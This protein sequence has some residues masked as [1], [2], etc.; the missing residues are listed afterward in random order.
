M[1]IDIET[2]RKTNGIGTKTIERIIEQ[3]N[4][5]NDL[6]S[7][8]SMYQPSDTYKINRD[9][10]LWKGDCLELMEHI[11]D[12]S[13]DMILCDLPYGT[14]ACKWDTVIPF[15]PLWD[16]YKRIIKDNGAIVLFGS[17][18]FT[19]KL[20]NSNINNFK[21]EWVWEKQ[22]GANFMGAKYSPIKYH[23]NIVVFGKTNNSKVK[24]YPQK[25]NVIELDDILN[26]NKKE[27]KHF[28]DNRLYDRYGKIDRRKTINNIP[29]PK[30]GHYG[31]MSLKIRNADDGTRFPKSVIKI[32][33]SI[34]KNLHPTQKPV[35]LL[36][37]LVKTYTD[38]NMLVLD[39]TMGVGST[40]VACKNT[41]RKFIGIELDE[42]YFNIASKRILDK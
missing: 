20:I 12:N 40:G 32:N 8:K 36:E 28:M 35:E 16:N 18:P 5:D 34:N 2:L 24:Y 21:Y 31:K 41:N 27:L 22:K 25:T 17:Q 14:T 19:T 13:V 3:Y 30:D 15:E 11:P 1:K 29:N 37:Y 39:N 7:Y 33:K 9:I 38:E 23:E 42:E 10:N 4:L 6:K 26:M